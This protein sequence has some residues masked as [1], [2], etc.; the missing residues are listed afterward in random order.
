MKPGVLVRISVAVKRHHVQ[1]SGLQFRG[2]VPCHHA[3]RMEALRQTYRCRRSQKFYL[4]IRRQQEESDSG[5][6]VS[7]PH[8]SSNKATPPNSDTPYDPVEII[9][10]ET[11]P[12]DVYKA[13]YV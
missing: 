9:F 12:P 5:P 4:H 10:I 2:S 11:T 13:R 1:Q 7:A 6:D 8:M 3:G